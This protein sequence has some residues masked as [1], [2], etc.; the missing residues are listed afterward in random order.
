MAVYF[1][2]EFIGLTEHLCLITASTA[3]YA[4]INQRSFA[5]MILT[6]MNLSVGISTSQTQIMK[7]NCP[8]WPLSKSQITVGSCFLK[9]DKGHCVQQEWAIA[10]CAVSDSV[11]WS[12]LWAFI[13]IIT[14]ISCAAKVLPALLP[15]LCALAS[16]ATLTDF[17]RLFGELLVSYCTEIDLISSISC[18]SSIIKVSQ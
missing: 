18:W 8:I 5:E 9:H 12:H 14:F 13:I 1:L 7:Q 4:L 11:E 6:V 3:V 16:K 10:G 2:L 17:C 15:S